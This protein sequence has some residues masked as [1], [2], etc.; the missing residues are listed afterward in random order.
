MELDRLQHFGLGNPTVQLFANNLAHGRPLQRMG[1]EK[2][3]VKMWVA[4][5][6]GP[7]SVEC[8][9]WGAGHGE[10]PTGRFDLAFA[11]KI[12]EFRGRRTVQLSVLDWRPA[13]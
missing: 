11:P 5:A 1:N 12:N 4:A 6:D 2:Q 3:H 9:W 8:V 10:L 13:V 7:G